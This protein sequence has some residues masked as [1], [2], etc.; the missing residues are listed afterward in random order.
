MHHAGRGFLCKSMP[1]SKKQQ[2][3]LEQAAKLAEQ[4]QFYTAIPKFRTLVKAHPE[5]PEI[6]LHL[7]KALGLS[8]QWKEAQK[9]HRQLKR[10]HPHA[11]ELLV[12]IARDLEE[13]QDLQGSLD[14][15]SELVADTKASNATYL[16]DAH[17]HR[18]RLL[19]RT[20]QLDEANKAWSETTHYRNDTWG[21]HW[22]DGRLLQRAGKLKEAQAAYLAGYEK[23]TGENKTK[24]ASAMARLMDQSKDFPAAYQWVQAMI[25]LRAEEAERLKGVH[26]LSD[27]LP[28]LP[29]L[30]SLDKNQQQPL[31]FLTGLPR[32][33][34]TLLAHQLSQHY[35][36]DLSEEF[37][38]IK[39]LVE[40]AAFHPRKISPDRL[41]R[42]LGVK[43]HVAA[44][45]QAQRES[46][47]TTNPSIPLLDKN[48]S[49]AM[50]TPWLLAL[51]PK[52]KILWLERDPRDLWISSVT[53]D[54]P[55]NGAT[56]WWQSPADYGKWC[57]QL[58]ELRDQ[59]ETHLPAEQFIKVNY[60]DLVS[61]P[62]KVMRAIEERFSLTPNVET[63][64]Q[65]S[66][67]TSPSYQEVIKPINKDRLMRWQQYCPLLDAEEQESFDA[68]LKLYPI[69]PEL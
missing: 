58:A 25:N 5:H 49:M 48:P 3:L 35:Q 16:P 31:I 60:R 9:W 22:L 19:E 2:R 8:G 55:L 37:D 59:L 50:L 1:N 69:V 6:Q 67:V 21:W 44:Y 24:C 11:R 43:K 33:G 57:Q 7:A 41:A 63:N 53:L 15:W 65:T 68:L 17:F 62:D 47:V 42:K 13:W 20:N 28:T 18:V 54:V 64:K 38:Y 30:K 27:E 23:A 46:G 36:I 39:Y 45:W 26:P 29:D 61:D 66:M 52:M 34:T 56:C 10:A 4:G 32:S 12:R 51:F 14:V 40:N